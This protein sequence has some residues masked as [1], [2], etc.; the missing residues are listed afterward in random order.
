MDASRVRGTREGHGVGVAGNVRHVREEEEMD[1]GNVRF[2]WVAYGLLSFLILHVHLPWEGAWIWE[3][4]CACLCPWSFAG[5]KWKL[6]TPRR[7]CGILYD[8]WSMQL[9]LTS[10]WWGRVLEPLTLPC[11]F[12]G[13]PFLVEDTKIT[14]YVLMG[15]IGDGVGFQMDCVFLLLERVRPFCGYATT[16]DWASFLLI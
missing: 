8:Y 10:F 16:Q 13:S 2:G 14:P 12:I 15:W 7:V 5:M 6:C 1:R 11:R 3:T 9:W 4:F